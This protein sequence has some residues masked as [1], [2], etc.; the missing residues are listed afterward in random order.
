MFDDSVFQ[1]SDDWFTLG[2]VTPERLAALR[3]EWARGEDRH[4]EH[5]RWRAFIAFLADH[6]PLTPDLAAA[7]YE[8]GARDPDSHAMG[9]SM[10]DRIVRLPE[11]PEKVLDAAVASGRRHLVRLVERRRAESG[12]TR[13]HSD[14]AA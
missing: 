6:R 11:C 7:L 2:V 1:F 14:P 12:D 9:S 5:Y 13:R 8:L 3:A 4:P 10:I